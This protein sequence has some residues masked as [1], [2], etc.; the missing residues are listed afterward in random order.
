M[1]RPILALAT[2][3]SSL[4]GAA[5]AEVSQVCSALLDGQSATIVVP[6]RPGGGYDT[7][8]RAVA[9][10]LAEHSGMMVRVI[11][12]DAG[13]GAVARELVLAT[14]EHD[15][16]ILIDNAVQLALEPLSP[17]S[18]EF[19]ISRFDTL[20]FAIVEPDSWVLPEG[21][22]LADTSIDHMV[23]AQGSVWDSLVSV[24]LVGQALGIEADVVGGYSGS[25]EFVAAVLRGEVDMTTV[26]LQTGLK[27]SL[28]N[29]THVALV[30]SDVPNPKA[31]GVAHLAGEDGLAAKRSAGLDVETR[32]RRQDLA[33]AAV[34][35]S[36]EMR[37]LFIS[38]ALP[39]NMRSCL[40][41][42]MAVAFADPAVAETVTAQGRQ[43]GAITGRAALERTALVVETAL[44]HQELLDQLFVA[45]SD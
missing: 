7:Y 5:T 15:I 18:D 45:M 22:D 27:R 31:P 2:V 36:G 33:R 26:S 39:E 30:V 44:A 23:A 40:R 43:L 16:L 19:A 9:P 25:G 12:N 29:D 11:N 6:N 35:L 24:V 34:S 32:E 13:G 10:A 42:A 38:S 4:A 21:M 28:G 14:P 17:G 37:G 41:E 20:A 3:L 1:M 8:A